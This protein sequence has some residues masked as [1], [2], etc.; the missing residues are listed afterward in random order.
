MF[1]PSRKSIPDDYNEWDKT[2]LCKTQLAAT[3]EAI[4][5]GYAYLA[6]TK[7]LNNDLSYTR[8]YAADLQGAELVGTQ[9]VGTSLRCANLLNAK[10]D[11]NTKINK[12]EDDKND[13]SMTD[14]RLA[15]V[16]LAKVDKVKVA[17]F[18]HTITLSEE[19]WREWQ[20]T[21]SQ[22]PN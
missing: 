20:K 7:F 10:M 11:G 12:F 8:L 22:F 5:K 9:L 1:T 17:Q 15:N 6:S 4:R 18:T 14:T 3:R 19:N 21:I 16:D 13:W 2:L